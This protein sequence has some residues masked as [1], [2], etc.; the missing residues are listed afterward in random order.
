MTSP[1]HRIVGCVLGTVHFALWMAIFLIATDEMMQ[2]HAWALTIFFPIWLVAFV[3]LVFLSKWA[4]EQGM[5]AVRERRSGPGEKR[6]S[7]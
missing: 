3:V 2:Y 5:A 6:R 1:R 7:G 4:I